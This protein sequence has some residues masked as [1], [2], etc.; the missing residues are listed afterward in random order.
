MT[1]FKKNLEYMS[2]DGSFAVS[3][4]VTVLENMHQE[5]L[6]A[7]PNETGGILVGCYSED[8]KFATIS[9]MLGKSKNSILRR[10]SFTRKGQDYLQAL[11]QLWSENQY[12]LGEWH[13]HPLSSP[14]PSSRDTETMI[15]LSID[16]GLNCP[17]P[18]LIIIGG[19]KNAWTI[20]VSVFS[21]GKSIVLS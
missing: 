5:C 7:L 2:S 10:S 13:Y 3:L 19:N 20:S 16:K 1:A 18:V 4:P 9:N 15:K 6:K 8:L 21:N 17:E 14:S 11:D 12:Y